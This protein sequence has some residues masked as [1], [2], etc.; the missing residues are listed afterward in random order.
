MANQPAS[1]LACNTANTTPP[2]SFDRQ[3]FDLI[4]SD[5]AAAEQGIQTRRIMLSLARMMEL[6]F[7]SFRETQ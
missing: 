5:C 4:G 3:N 1:L 6:D 2:R 7:L